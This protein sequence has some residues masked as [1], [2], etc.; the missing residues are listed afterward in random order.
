MPLISIRYLTDLNAI[1]RFAQTKKNI[2][3]K[4]N[5]RS[6]METL[7]TTFKTIFTVNIRV[8]K[9][10]Y[11]RLCVVR[12]ENFGNSSDFGRNH[13]ETRRRKIR[14]ENILF[15]FISMVVFRLVMFNLI[16]EI[17]NRRYVCQGH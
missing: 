6:S 3:K 4:E 15:F 17:E 10:H 9:N 12:R 14:F 5:K 8:T 11:V 2:S 16:M 1:D 13:Q 7:K